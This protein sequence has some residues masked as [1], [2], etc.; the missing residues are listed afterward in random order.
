MASSS[1]SNTTHRGPLRELRV[2]P[3]ELFLLKNGLLKNG[4]LK[5]GQSSSSEAVTSRAD[6]AANVGSAAP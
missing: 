1:D 4:L 6:A 2:V 5:N 3:L